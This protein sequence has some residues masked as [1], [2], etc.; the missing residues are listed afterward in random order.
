VPAA[1]LIEWNRKK[2]ASERFNL[3]KELRR[4]AVYS[5]YSQ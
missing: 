2:S 4:K 1:R 3:E 5:Y